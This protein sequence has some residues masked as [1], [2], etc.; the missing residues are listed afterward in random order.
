MYVGTLSTLGIGQA[1][2]GLL[3]NENG[4]IVDDGIV[5]RLGEQR[6]WVN[7]TSGRAERTAAAFE[8]WLQCEFVNLK[9]AVTPVTSRW[10]NVTIAGPRAWEWLEA[11]GFDSVLAPTQMKHMSMVSSTLRGVPLRVLRASFSGELGYEINVPTDHGRL[12]FDR[13]WSLGAR[14]S[15]VPYGIEALQTMRIE[16]GYIHIGT[17]T[18]GTTLPIDIGFG[19]AIDRKRANFVGRRSL[20][21]PAAKD[22]NRL[23]LVALTPTDGRT[24]LPVGAQ[25]AQLPPTTLTEGHVTSS[26]IST[27]SGQPIALA[28]LVRGAVRTGERVRVHHLGKSIEADIVTA[29]CFDPQ[30]LRQHG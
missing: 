25:I 13:L 2:Y 4:V 18:D 15:A 1:R 7:T 6:F 11:T 5:A 9:V 21:R 12:L 10:T 17:D 20:G 23:Q 27:M 24:L 29:P 22:P 26:A 8:E 14:F 3:L 30:G 19:R 16:K 28:M